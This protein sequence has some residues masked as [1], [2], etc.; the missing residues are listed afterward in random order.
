MTNDVV[1][2]A[3]CLGKKYTI[4]H[5]RER[6]R[7]VALRDVIASRAKRLVRSSFNFYNSGVSAPGC[8]TEEFWALRDV[9]FDVRQGEVVGVIG[10][11]GAGKSTLL[12]VLSRITEPSEGRVVIQGRVA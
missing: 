2:R 1:I 10:R 9:N 12:K 3:E 4:C 11:N 5:Q 8:A 6:E 7:Y